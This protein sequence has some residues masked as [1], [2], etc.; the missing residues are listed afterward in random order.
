MSLAVIMA[1]LAAGTVTSGR[2]AVQDAGVVQSRTSTQNSG[3]YR[4]VVPAF[5]E[6]TGTAM[7]V[8]AVGTGQALQNA[9]NCAGD[10]LITPANEAELDFVARG[11]GTL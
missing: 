6:E 10:L 5:T 7:R 3:F 2:A 9:R 1:A 4:H 8:I 11:Y